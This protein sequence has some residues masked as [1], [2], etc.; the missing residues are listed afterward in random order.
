MDVTLLGTLGWMP[1]GARETTCFAVRDGLEP[2]AVRRGHRPAPAPRPGA[3]R[4]ARGRRRGAP[5]P[6]PLPPRPRLRTRV[7]LRRAAGARRRHPPARR[8]AHGRRPAG[9]RGGAGPAALQPRRPRR[10]EAR[11]RAAHGRRARTRSPATSCA[12]GRSSTPT[13]ASRSASTTSSSSP[14]TRRSDPA[15]VAF[16]E[17]AGLWLHEAWYW[18]DDPGL[19]DVPAELRPGYAAHSEATAVAGLAARGRR[20][21]PDPRAP[22]P[23][24]PASARTC[25]CATRRA[26]C[27]RTPTSWRTGR[28]PR[29]RRAFDTPGRTPRGF[30]RG[31]GMIRFRDKRFLAVAI[32]VAALIVFVLP[33]FVAFRYTAPEQRGQFLTRPWRGWSFAYAALAVPGGSELKTVGHGAA[34]GRLAVQG[35][36]RRPARGPAALRQAQAALHVPARHRRPDGDEHR[37]AELPVHLA[38]A[39]GDRHGL[40]Q[41]P[42]PSSRCSTTTP[43][44]CST[45]SATT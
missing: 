33:A 13:R 3:R 21:P 2:A 44:G 17:G 45:T 30:L 43:G 25:P 20:R 23:A 10:H 39:G 22:Q 40:R 36:R 8:G 4:P 29:P 42:T 38:G 34:Q 27:S 37:R 5:L 35:H 18:A 9:R 14:R 28:W 19:A 32:V 15:A 41:R 16:A 24:R 11:A 12:C 31:P 1:R 26:R 6:E 7:P